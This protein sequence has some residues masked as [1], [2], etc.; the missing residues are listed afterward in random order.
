MPSKLYFNSESLS[1]PNDVIR[2][3][4]YQTEPRKPILASHDQLRPICWQDLFSTKDI[5][6]PERPQGPCTLVAFCPHTL[7]SCLSPV[8]RNPQWY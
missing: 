7:Q 8:A 3:D 1:W 2:D 4:E 6:S 5:D